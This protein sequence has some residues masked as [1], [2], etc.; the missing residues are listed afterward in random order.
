MYM[1]G[2]AHDAAVSWEP[3]R[4]LVAVQTSELFFPTIAVDSAG[5]PHVVW[6][7]AVGTG[8]MAEPDQYVRYTRY[9]VSSSAWI[10]PALQIDANPVR[11]N[12]QIPFY[13]VPSLALFEHGDRVEVC[14][15]WHGFRA[16]GIGEEILLSCSWDQGQSWSVPE[17][18]SRSVGLEAMSLAPSIAFDAAGRLHGVWQEHN[19]KMG[20]NVIYDYQVYHTRAL[21]EV[22]LPLVARN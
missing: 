13:T 20:D 10:S 11:T 14:V 17:N 18:A 6:G 1:R 3:A 4:E 9:D 5:N 2:H 15:A 8:S 19:D 12:Q 16:G 21:C 7:E 22:F